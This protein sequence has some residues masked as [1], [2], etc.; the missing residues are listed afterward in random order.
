MASE[1]NTAAEL[2]KLL[3]SIRKGF[4]QVL[5]DHGLDDL[6]VSHFELAAAAQA[7]RECGHWEDKCVD[8]GDTKKC[9]RVW[10][11]TPC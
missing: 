7:S 5:K 2:E 6:H 1:K 8:Q 3:P 4:R 11:S 10:V 9:T